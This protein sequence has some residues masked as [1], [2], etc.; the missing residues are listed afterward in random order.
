MFEQNHLEEAE[1]KSSNA[2]TEAQRRRKSYRYVRVGHVCLCVRMDANGAIMSSH[3]NISPLAGLS[4]SSDTLA[5]NEQTKI[6]KSKCK[7]AD[8]SIR[9]LISR[10]C[11]RNAWPE[12]RPHRNWMDGKR[13]GAFTGGEKTNKPIPPFNPEPSSVCVYVSTVTEH[14][15]LFGRMQTSLMRTAM[16]AHRASASTHA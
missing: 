11:I 8:L 6:P 3:Q 1:R 2:D 9:L 13:L 12:T 5:G 10:V 4:L 16:N 7:C 15:C 14:I